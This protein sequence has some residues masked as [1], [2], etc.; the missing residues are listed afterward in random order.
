MYTKMTIFHVILLN[1]QQITHL[2]R[3]EKLSVCC[4]FCT[5]N[6]CLQCA[7]AH[8]NIKIWICHQWL[9]ISL[10]LSK[11][12]SVTNASG[13][14]FLL[15]FIF[16]SGLETCE[17]LSSEIIHLMTFSSKQAKEQELFLG[18]PSCL[19]ATVNWRKNNPTL[20]S[21]VSP[22]PQGPCK[23]KKAISPFIHDT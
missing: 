5:Q 6:R 20:S 19:P 17:P 10:L 16:N 2:K 7:F 23:R 1:F 15:F 14:F 11:C 3:A 13:F 18:P 8:L 9:I 21:R 12:A 4:S 22:C